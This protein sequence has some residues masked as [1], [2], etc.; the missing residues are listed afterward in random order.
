MLGA[1]A[2]ALVAASSGTSA[3]AQATPTIA[4]AF[5]TASISVG[6]RASLT[7]TLS[8]NTGP[9]PA[10]QVRFTD[11]LPAGLVVIG[12]RAGGGSVLSQS[13]GCCPMG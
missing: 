8:D 5:G 9:I 10:A 11:S 6:G 7:F 1:I 4:E 12:A 13:V 2:A 3:L